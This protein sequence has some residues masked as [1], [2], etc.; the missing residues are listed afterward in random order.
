MVHILTDSVS[1]LGKE[2]S[3]KFGIGIIPLSVFINNQTFSDGGDLTSEML[4][5]EVEK[6][7]NCPRLQ[8]HL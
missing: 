4:Y 5:A 1:D 2:L 8:R 3:Q 7:D 6:P